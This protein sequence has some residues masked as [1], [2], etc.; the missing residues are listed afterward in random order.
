MRLY[1]VQI[2]HTVLISAKIVYY[3]NVNKTPDGGGSYV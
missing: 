1:F 2:L 3:K